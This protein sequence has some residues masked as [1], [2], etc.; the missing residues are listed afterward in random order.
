M[1]ED[2]ILLAVRQAKEEY[3]A[4]HG[5]NIREIVADLRRMDEAGDWQIVSLIP[6]R[7]PIVAPIHSLIRS[8]PIDD[9]RV[10]GMT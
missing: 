6:K 1:K 5:F 2:D 9:E 3:A 4:T 8:I 7:D 10:V